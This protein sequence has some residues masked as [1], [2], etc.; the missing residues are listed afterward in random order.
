MSGN[1]NPVSGFADTFLSKLKE[2]SFTIIVMVGIIWYQGRMMEERVAYWQKL[3]EEKEAYI[4]QTT[5][6]D[7]EDLLE[8]IKY[9]QDQRDKYVEDAI[10]ELKDK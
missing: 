8:R 3:Y 6:E 10:N 1:T 5:K 7:R 4:E 9:L 2:Q